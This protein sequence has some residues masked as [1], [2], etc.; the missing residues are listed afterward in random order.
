MKILKSDGEIFD[1]ELEKDLLEKNRA[2][3]RENR[4]RFDKLNLIAIDVMGSIGSGKTSLIKAILKKLNMGEKI[5]VIAGDL[6][7]DIDGKRISEESARVIQINTGKECHL[8]A[9]IIDLA[10]KKMNLNGP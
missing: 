10:I 1:I 5:G 6:T 7:T 4:K 9:H 2:L 8:D 3:A